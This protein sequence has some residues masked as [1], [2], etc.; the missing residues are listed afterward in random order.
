[1]KHNCLKFLQIYSKNRYLKYGL[2]KCF[3]INIRNLKWQDKLNK[4]VLM[5]YITDYFLQIG[6][7]LFEKI[8]LNALND[9]Y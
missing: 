2:I 6:K 9:F 5:I 1:M 4:P 7:T 8:G 3:H